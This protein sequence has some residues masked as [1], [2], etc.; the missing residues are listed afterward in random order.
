MGLFGGPPRDIKALRR[1]IEY[2]LILWGTMPNTPAQMR[3]HALENVPVNLRAK[4]VSAQQAG[5][6]AEAMEVIRTAREA[7]PK[8]SPAEMSWAQLLNYAET[9][10]RPPPG[11][12][13]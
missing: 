7:T 4:V 13:T 3:Q 11:V 8:A 5:H 2:C 9:G 12:V 10:Q 6:L 1:E